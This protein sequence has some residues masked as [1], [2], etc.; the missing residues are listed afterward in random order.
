M[1]IMGSKENREAVFGPHIE[2]MTGQT[3]PHICHL[4]FYCESLEVHFS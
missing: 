2:K 3:T 4:F 1:M